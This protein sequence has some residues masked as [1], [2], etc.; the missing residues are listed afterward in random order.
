MIFNAFAATDAELAVL[1]EPD[2][3]WVLLYVDNKDENTKDMAQLVVAWC[4][5]THENGVIELM[6]R[7]VSKLQ[8]SRKN[9]RKASLYRPEAEKK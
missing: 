2:D 4:M 1:L 8:E 6:S 5:T 3:L 7:A 9:E